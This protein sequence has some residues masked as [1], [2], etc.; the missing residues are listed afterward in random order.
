MEGNLHEFVLPATLGVR[1]LPRLPV[2]MA[3]ISDSADVSWKRLEGDIGYIYVRRIK[4]ELTG[5]LDRAVAELAGARGLIVDVRGNSGG[6]FDIGRSHRNFD[7]GD[8]GEP[9]RPRFTRPMALLID[10]RCISAGEGWASW[11]IA[12]QRAKVFGSA[13]A[14]ASARK[15]TYSLKNG[16]YRV[17]FPVKAYA[18]YLSRPIELRG[19]EPDVPVR[20][21][22]ADLAAG[23]DTVLQ[24]AKQYLLATRKKEHQ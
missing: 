11:F 5:S 15:T 1:Y 3:G 9:N 14:G 18:G 8:P 23:R 20:Q 6:G 21:T 4:G 17:R 7:P 12:N 10:S 19:L 22:A 16:L 2:P 13:T 24:A